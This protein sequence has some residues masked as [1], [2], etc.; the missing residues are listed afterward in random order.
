VLCTRGF[1]NH[2]RR[3]LILWLGYIIHQKLAK[4]EEGLET[5]VGK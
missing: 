5:G 4:H 3:M 1:K 2:P